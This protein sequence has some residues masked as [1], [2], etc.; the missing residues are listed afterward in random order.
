[1]TETTPITPN[2]QTREP[3]MSMQAD[4]AFLIADYCSRWL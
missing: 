2:H 3:T 1:M 4:L